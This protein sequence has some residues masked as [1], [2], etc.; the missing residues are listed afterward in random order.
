MQQV[1]ALR[2]LQDVRGWL[3]TVLACLR[4][5][6]YLQ[7]PGLLPVIRDL[8]R[9]KLELCPES[10]LKYWFQRHSWLCQSLR[11]KSMLMLPHRLAPACVFVCVCV[12][13]AAG[14][15]YGSFG[16][17]STFHSSSFISPG[18]SDYILFLCGWMV[19]RR[20]Q[21]PPKIKAFNISHMPCPKDIINQGPEKEWPRM[22]KRGS[23]FLSLEPQEEEGL[24]C[25]Q[26]F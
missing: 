14:G 12:H 24:V 23:L 26:P 1:H 25:L 19:S 18:F 22:N 10:T 4:K 17:R 2:E 21:S 16:Q 9:P 8:I 6:D 11:K 15:L 13:N 3:A 7:S 5:T 20:R